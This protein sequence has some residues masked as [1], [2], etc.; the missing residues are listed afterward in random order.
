MNLAENMTLFPENEMIKEHKIE[1]WNMITSN[2]FKIAFL[3]F[4]NR[5]KT[6]PE[7]KPTHLE[8]E[9]I[10]QQEERMNIELKEYDDFLTRENNDIYKNGDE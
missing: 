7:I 4:T 2:N 10:R 5:G 9:R 6:L 8:H 3:H 1:Y